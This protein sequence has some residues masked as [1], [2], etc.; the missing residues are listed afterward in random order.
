MKKFKLD[1]MKLKVQFQLILFFI[2]L[3]AS[4]FSQEAIS[5]LMAT[6][7]LTQDSIYGLSLIHFECEH[8][9]NLSKVEIRFF[10]E[11][12]PDTEPQILNVF[13]DQGKIMLRL[14]N[15]E[16]IEIKDSY[17]V[18]TTELSNPGWEP[19][20]YIELDCVLKDNS[21]TNTLTFHRQQFTY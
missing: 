4:S 13:E 7:I 6:D 9:E 1:N 5:N 3:S 16:E 17:V 8:P 12:M 21:R 20:F 10:S 15:D 14:L 2:L 18:F 11:N 19:Y